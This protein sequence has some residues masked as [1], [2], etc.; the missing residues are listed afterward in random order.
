MTTK[1]L[2]VKHTPA[3][4]APF[5]LDMT[6]AEIPAYIAKCISASSSS[7]FYFVAGKDERGDVDIAHVGNGPRGAENARL[8]ASAPDLLEALQMFMKAGVGNSA[9]HGMQC[10]A[11]NLGKKAIA[12]ATGVTA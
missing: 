7:D 10:C 8:I 12:N 2:Q 11:A 5:I 9:D 1:E 3:P 4:W 6:L